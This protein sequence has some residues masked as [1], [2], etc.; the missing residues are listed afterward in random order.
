[1]KVSITEDVIV[2]NSAGQTVESLPVMIGETPTAGYGP[3]EVEEDA[4]GVPVRIVEDPVAENSIGQP[5]D[6]LLVSGI[7]AP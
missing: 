5:V 3:V 4:N 6:V 2:I 1:M 7:E